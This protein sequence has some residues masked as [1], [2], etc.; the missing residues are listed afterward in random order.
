MAVPALQRTLQ[1]GGR[2][3][4]RM[5]LGTNRLTE[6]TQNADFIRDAVAA[7]VAMLDTAH[8]YTSGSSGRTI[9][10]AREAATSDVAVATKAGFG[11]GEGKPD[12]LRAQIEQSL[13]QLRT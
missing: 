7:G 10:S 1:V 6:T 3:V 13:R 5:G 12:V 2:E 11:R 8:L 9:G 4:A